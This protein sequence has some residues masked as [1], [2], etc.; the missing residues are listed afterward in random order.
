[1]EKDKKKVLFFFHERYIS[2]LPETIDLSEDIN[3]KFNELVAF[4]YTKN[5]ITK[6]IDSKTLYSIFRYVGFNFRLRNEIE[7]IAVK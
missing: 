5:I 6:I 1:M 2:I 4:I 3:I 7:L